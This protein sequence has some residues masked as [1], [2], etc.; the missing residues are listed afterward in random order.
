M[1][2]VVKNKDIYLEN[3]A[4][5][6]WRFIYSKSINSLRDRFD[7]V[8]DVMEDNDEDDLEWVINELQE[9][10]HESPMY[11]DAYNQ[12][13]L[14]LLWD[15]YREEG[16][17]VLEKG[18]KNIMSI[19]PDDFFES[20]NLLKWGWLENRPFLR[21][22][23]NLGLFLFENKKYSR[24]KSIFEKILVMNP[25][26]NQWIRD[27]LL[28]CYLRLNE[29]TSAN[30]LCSQ[31]E[32][33]M[34]VGISYGSA[35]VS[36][37]LKDKD[38]AEKKFLSAMRNAPRVAK[39]LVKAKHIKPKNYGIGPGIILG[40]QEEAYEYWLSFGDIWKNTPAAI[41]FVKSCL[42]K[43]KKVKFDLVDDEDE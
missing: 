15:G 8:C 26:D 12:L 39:E 13:A 23:A 30:N 43:F 32:N 31:Y 5:K 24:A 3:V 37:I 27:P 7:H 19:F 21:C 14:I 20:N 10:I 9:I 11:I 40:S 34:L 35:L 36:F 2:S 1:L 25:N 41:L 16:Q 6:E 4:N 33:D 38:K 29:L 42:E 28:N 17:A 22:Y 18:I